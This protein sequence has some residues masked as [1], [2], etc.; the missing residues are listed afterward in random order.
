MPTWGPSTCQVGPAPDPSVSLECVL[1]DSGQQPPGA[2]QQ[3]TGDFSIT[4]S[5]QPTDFAWAAKVEQLDPTNVVF[6]KSQP[7]TARGSTPHQTFT[8]ACPTN[9][10]RVRVLFAAAPYPGQFATCTATGTF[11]GTTPCVYGT[12]LT[13]GGQLVQTVTQATLLTWLNRFGLGWLLTALAS[14]VGL[15]LDAQKL[16]GSGPPPLPPIS[17]ETLSAAPQTLL[18][19]LEAVAWGNLCE[20]RAGTP[21]PVPFPPPSAVQ[22]PGWPSP[23]TPACSNTDLCGLL[24]QVASQLTTVLSV[25]N[26]NYQLTTLVQRFR[27]PF[28]FIAGAAHGALTDSGT[29]AI[30]RLIGFEITVTS[31]PSDKPTFIGNPPYVAD[32]GWVSVSEVD[33]MVQE[34]RVSQDHFSWFPEIVGVADHFNWALQPNVVIRVTELQAEP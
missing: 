21:A 1:F 2:I 17:L 6:L 20:C 3:V 11:A 15:Q 12:Q 25:L 18:Q 29:F 8:I 33:G 16:C 22:P 30:P 31:R 23:I 32:L 34:R 14:F 7:I 10:T 19:I 5:Q 24:T 26:S 27:V 28:A 4:F 9:T 13:A